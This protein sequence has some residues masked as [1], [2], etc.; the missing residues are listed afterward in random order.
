MG[1]ARASCLKKRSRKLLVNGGG[2]GLAEMA[3]TQVGL[4]IKVFLR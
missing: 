3:P 1:K 4:Q 2:G